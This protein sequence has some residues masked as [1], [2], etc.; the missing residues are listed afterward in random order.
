MRVLPHLGTACALAAL[1]ATP[2]AAPQPPPLSDSRIAVI[3]P[4]G[5]PLTVIAAD[6]SASEFEPRGGALVIELAGLVRFRH[7]GAN[8]VRA[9]TLAVRAHEQRLG[10]RAA[11]SV[12]SLHAPHGDDFDVHVN[13]RMLRPL[14]VPPGPVVRV[15]ADAVLFDTLASA[16]PDSLGS[17]QNMKVLEM[18]ARRDREHFLAV[19]RA[20]GREHLAS[21]MQ[22]SIR[23]QAA[24]P[25]L[26]VRLAGDGPATAGPFGGPRE[27]QFA[28]IQDAD[29]P[30]L[31][32]SGSAVVTGTVTDTPRIV[33]RNRSAVDVSRF[34]LGWLVTDADGT[35]YSL[36]KVPVGARRSLRPG[37]R[38]ET[39]GA[40]RFEFRSARAGEP[41]QVRSMSAYV[42]SVSLADGRMWVPSRVDLQQSGLLESIPVSVEEQRLSLLY[43]DRGPD[44]VLEEL[45]K[46]QT[47][48]EN[49][50]EP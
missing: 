20:G 29:A 3:I 34:E 32:D 5:V 40:G 49:P 41:V 31:L 37:K 44:A 33:L 48:A 7:E 36:G 10:G 2:P 12:P 26:D 35:A 24:R 23:R 15:V 22:A 46:L 19:W 16:G 13:L 4:D 17:V 14:P 28:F 18:E 30:L 25:H 6:F 27:V 42:R 1:V 9:I 8:S 50:A 21:A 38:M 43:R 45:R 11:V 47:L 39:G